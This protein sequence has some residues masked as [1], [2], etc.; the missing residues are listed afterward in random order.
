MRTTKEIFEGI[1]AKVFDVDWDGPCKVYVAE[2]LE[3]D[4]SRLLLKRVRGDG[5]ALAVS[6]LEFVQMILGV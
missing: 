6:A 1:T 2:L 3:V 4:G 5:E